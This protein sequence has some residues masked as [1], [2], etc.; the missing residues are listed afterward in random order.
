[1]PRL[2]SSWDSV[3]ALLRRSLL[4]AL[5]ALV[6]GV[7]QT[8]RAEAPREH[9][10][11]VRTAISDEVARQNDAGN[12]NAPS[13][14]PLL[15]PGRLAPTPVPPGFNTFDGGWIRFHYHPSSREAL[16]AL[17][18]EATQIRTELNERLGVPVLSHVR[19][20]LARTPGEMAT[21]APAGAPYP[22]YAAGVAYSEAGL[23]L[24]TL[25]PVHPTSQHDLVE[26]FRHELAHVA[27]FDAVASAHVPR[28]F[29]EGFAVF[30]SGESSFKRLPTLWRATLADTLVPLDQLDQVFPLDQNDAD[31]AYAEAADVVRFLVRH[32]ERFRF[33]GLVERMRAGQDFN[34]SIRDAYGIEVSELEQEWREDVAK[35]YTF[36]PVLLS[37]SVVWFG[38]LGLFALGYRKRKK[39][40]TVTLARWAEE[41]ARED[42]MRRASTNAGSDDRIHIV[43]ARGTG[44]QPLTLP[45]PHET[46]EVPKVQHEGQW[47]TLH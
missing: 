44:S 8:A 36:W 43:L 30:A 9:E 42:A 25:A 16:Q 5:M 37:G 13:D 1:M 18:S 12:K 24:L 14:A 39:R 10:P 17:I 19:V 26:V 20:D 33:Q 23:V 29:N 11:P 3:L 35:R 2:P 40:A 34:T 7:G 6:L 15:G 46:A 21:F 31:V 41:E 28:W 22:D 47:H 27:L 4:L 38:V 32:R 45:A